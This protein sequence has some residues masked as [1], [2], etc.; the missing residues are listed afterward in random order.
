MSSSN[1]NAPRGRLSG[2]TGAAPTTTWWWRQRQALAAAGLGPDPAEPAAHDLADI[3]TWEAVREALGARFDE[4]SV[5]RV[6][7]LYRFETHPALQPLERAM[8][9]AGAIKP[10]GVRCVARARA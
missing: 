3:F 5:Q 7:Y 2:P 4:E 9:D 10:T 8:I 6:E 1:R